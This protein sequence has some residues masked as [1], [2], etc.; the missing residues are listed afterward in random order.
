MSKNKK[1]K[2]EGAE[3][4]IHGGD[5]KKENVKTLSVILAEEAAGG[6]NVVRSLSSL[7]ARALL[8]SKVPNLWTPKGHVNYGQWS[9]VGPALV[10]FAKSLAL[11]KAKEKLVMGYIFEHC[12]TVCYSRSTISRAPPGSYHPGCY[13]SP[14][15]DCCICDHDQHCRCDHCGE[16]SFG[17]Y[18][19]D[20]SDYTTDEDEEETEEQDSDDE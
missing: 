14:S 20:E 6:F 18:D 10:G 2:A 11:E 4:L 9:D 1:V 13:V 17:G 15:C 3:G 12:N 19:S 16:G 7:S 8:R 5:K